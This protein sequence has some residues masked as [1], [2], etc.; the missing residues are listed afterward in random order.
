MSDLDRQR[1][2]YSQSEPWPASA[3]SGA[4]PLTAAEASVSDRVAFIRKVYALFFMN[5][6]PG[7]CRSIWMRLTFSSLCFEY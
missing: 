4:P 1:H 6:L 7:R 3:E 5:T 2:S